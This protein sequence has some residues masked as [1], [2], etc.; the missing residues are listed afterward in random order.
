MEKKKEK[1]R[2]ARGSVIS[3]GSQPGYPPGRQDFGIR[4]PLKERAANGRNKSHYETVHN[5]TPF[6]AEK[7]KNNLLAKIDAGEFFVARAI[8]LKDFAAEWL[9]QKARLGLKDSA[10]LAYRETIHYYIVPHIG[11]LFLGEIKGA[12]VRD[13]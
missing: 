3:L 13:L 5:V 11:R 2:R 1:V 4:V 6:Q 7:Y 8:T 10:L 12:T 9:Q